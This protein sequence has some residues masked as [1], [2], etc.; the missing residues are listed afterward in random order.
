MMHNPWLRA[1]V[2]GFVVLAAAARAVAEDWP[3]AAHDNRRTGVSGERLALP[4]QLAWIFRSPAPPAAG[5]PPPAN[6]YGARKNKSEASYDDA[7]RVVAAGGTAYFGSTAENALYAI[8]A[9]TGAIRWTWAGEAAPRLAPTVDG[10]RLVFGA[11]DGRVYCLQTQDGRTSWVFDARLTPERTLGYGR[12]SSLWPIRTGVMIEEGLAYFAAGLFPSEGIFLYALDPHSGQLRWRR[13]IDLEVQTGLPPQGDLLADR[14][15]IYLTSRVTPTRWTKRDG[16]HKPFYTPPPDVENNHEYR[17]YNGGSEARI[18]QDRYFVYGSACLLAY[19]PEK[20][21]VDKYGRQQPGDLLFH[22]FNARQAVFGKTRAFIATDYQLLAVDPARLPELGRGAC[23]AFERLYKR[24]R[25]ASRLDWLDQYERLCAELGEEHPRAQWIQQGPL[26]WSQADWEQ[27]LESSPAVFARLAGQAEWM[28]PLAATEAL[29]LAGDVLYAGSDDEVLALDAADGRVLWRDRTASR[30][31]GLA[32]SDG[33]LFVS[34]IDGSVRCYQAGAERVPAVRVRQLAAE[35]PS[36]HALPAALVPVVEHVAAAW[37]ER[38]GYCLVLGGGDGQLATALAQ[39]TR[40]HLQIL[41]PD[42]ARADQTRRRL[43]AAGLHGWRVC[44][45]TG[46]PGQLPYPPYLFNVV[47]D[48]ARVLGGQSP[49]PVAEAIRVARPLG[50]TV[51]AAAAGEAIAA[52]AGRPTDPTLAEVAASADNGPRRLVRGRLPN[53]ADW[54]HNY[55]TAANTYCNGDLQV[56]GPFGILWYG[57]PGPR[58]RI[59]RHATPPIPLVV[60]GILLTVADDRLL[61]FDAYNGIQ[62]WERWIVGVDRSGLPLAT[63]NLAAVGSASWGDNSSPANQAAG[64]DGV[65]TG[66][67]LYA[68]VNDR[69]C[70]QIDVATGR[71]LRVFQPPHR[72]AAEEASAGNGPEKGDRLALGERG[73]VSTPVCC[74]AS[75]ENG[76][77]HHNMQLSGLREDVACCG[78]S[79]GENA[80]KGD[81][82][83]NM[84]LSGLREGVACCGASPLFQPSLW[85]WI[86]TDGARVYGSRARSAGTRPDARYSDG[87]FA[88]AADSGAVCWQYLA[89]RIEHDGIALAAGRLFLVDEA[90]TDAEREQA[91]RTLPKDTSVPD[92]PAVDR[93]GQPVPRDLRKLIALD[94]ATG[95]T[96]WEVPFDATDITLDD[97]VVSDGRVGVACMIQD[98]VVI[99]HGTGSLGHPHRE[100]LAGEFARRALY[101]F[102]ADTGRLLWGGR[103]G[104]RKRPIIVG[105][106]VF[107]E[108]FAW[109]LHTG[110]QQ[111]IANPLSGQSQALDFHRGY[112]GCSHLLASGAALFGNKPGIASWNLDSPEG[113]VPF[114]SVVFGC[115]ICATPAGGVFVAP[116][117]RS[118][119]ACPAGIHTSLA[120]YPKGTPRAWGAGFTGGIAPTVSLPVRHAAI[121]LGAPGWRSDG[122][123]LWL[124]YPL[125]GEAGLIGNWLPRYQHRPEQFYYTAPELLPIGDTDLP[126]LYTS[127]CQADTEF[128]FRLAAADSASAT[129]T[130]RLHFAEPDD[131]QPGQRVFD[132]RLQ[133]QVVLSGFDVVRAA[134]GPRRA[135][136][137]EFAGIEVTGELSIRLQRSAAASARPPLLCA[138][139]VLRE[140]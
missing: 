79:A 105:G 111:M 116:E 71:T 48:Q 58:D 115:G 134:G 12:F 118:G 16:Q 61:A 14:D 67:S 124:P 55:G 132:V 119:C 7:P 130:V 4:L 22:W 109:D 85:A 49:T 25:V 10:D 97:T 35:P 52:A 3:T 98:G 73:C 45:A 125:R 33:R 60:D 15:S 114:D 19:D 30:V 42:P 34:T 69:E 82:H 89:Q 1:A 136:V 103:R 56:H 102:S 51:Y 36:Q 70:W 63:S 11:D 40:L 106:R 110:Q 28:T 96:M 128:K 120:L 20:T 94:A 83:H 54:T 23:D 68:V 9:A 117:G 113:F 138:V 78:A 84:Q 72:E 95:R 32:V 137:K 26:K 29:I 17:F 88:L 21:R 41:E 126:W 107:A 31:R 131:T 135:I 18:W 93:R 47:I 24:H 108:P 2:V 122:Q 81:R 66:A 44:C 112:I 13:Q 5:W 53:T 127:G 87:L 133:G 37:A 100:F 123:R 91:L 57:D 90:A 38:P 80:E 129:Y 39:R 43:L 92:R 86:A 27:W 104:Y 65:A 8:D 64:P 139:E 59:D 140:E 50:G 121:N 62:H 77:R 99:V 6:G 101:A 74:G 46:D 75:A 76:D